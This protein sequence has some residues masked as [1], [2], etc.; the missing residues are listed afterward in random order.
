MI[1]ELITF[2]ILFSIV[3][4]CIWFFGKC[5]ELKDWNNGFCGKCGEKWENFDTDSQGGRGYTCLD[6]HYIWCSYNVDKN[7]IRNKK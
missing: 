4:S 1:N 6:N 3:G 7:Y 5:W 2:S